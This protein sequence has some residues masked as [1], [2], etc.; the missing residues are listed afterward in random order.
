MPKRATKNLDLSL[1]MTCQRCGAPFRSRRY[2]ADRRK[3]CSK[4]CSNRSRPQKV[5][6][7]KHGYPQVTTPDGR[8]IAMHRHVMEQKIGRRLLPNETV[9]HKD[10]NRANYAEDNLELWTGRHGRGQRATDVFHLSANDFVR[11]ALS[12]GG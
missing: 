1:D 2:N 6:L 10:G 7:D 4:A 3:F 9:H 5:W 8:K 12:M 11:G